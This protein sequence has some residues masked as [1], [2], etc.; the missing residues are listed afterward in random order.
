MNTSPRIVVVG[1]GPAGLT[2]ASILQ[3]NGLPVTVLDRDPTVDARNQGG[4][5]DL[6]T[7]HGQPAL[8]EAG[9]L[10][11]FLDRSRPEGQEMRRADRAGNLLLRI[12]PEPDESAKPEIDRGDLRDLLLRSLAPGTVRWGVGVSGVRGG[13]ELLTTDGTTI[14]ADLIIGADGAFSRIRP[15]LSPTAPAYSGI[16]FLEAWF[17]DVSTRH[18]ELT[19]FVGQGLLAAADGERALFAQRNG[20]DHLRVYIIQKRP[21]DWISRSGLT[22]TDTAAL[23]AHLLAE[24]AAWGPMPRRMLTDNDGPFVDRPIFAL[25]APYGW[26]HSPTVT[27]IG[28]AAHLMPPIGLGVNL[29]M[30]DAQDLALA[31]IGAATV[32]EALLGYEKTMLARADEIGANL[33]RGAEGL[34][35]AD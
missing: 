20:G 15:T 19:E 28:D 33:G 11:A 27:L 16:T 3:K 6:D 32:D 17:D 34:L 5:L 23:R 7:E 21:V 25:P 18:P 10:Q 24:F 9:L 2:C 12:V 13:R 22:T 8:A 30:H 1:A 14:E 35:D 31:L 4:S 29:A 26:E